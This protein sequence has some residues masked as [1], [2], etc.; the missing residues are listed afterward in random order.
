MLHCSILLM[1][2]NAL[3]EVGVFRFRICYSSLFLCLVHL[4]F[5]AVFFLARFSAL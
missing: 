4:Q 5:L 2:L 1:L 3:L